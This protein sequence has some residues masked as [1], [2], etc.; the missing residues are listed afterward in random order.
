[1]SQVKFDVNPSEAKLITA[2]AERYAE[3]M[4]EHAKVTMTDEA[5]LSLRMDLTACHC[6]GCQL[7][8][9]DLLAAAEFDLAHD[10]GG[11]RNCMDRTTG[12]LNGGFLPR[13]ADVECPERG[14][15]FTKAERDGLLKVLQE[16]K[17]L[18]WYVVYLDD[19]DERKDYAAGTPLEDV[20]YDANQT[21]DVHLG[22]RFN[23]VGKPSANARI[24]LVWGN[25]PV[26]LI[27]DWSAALAEF[28]EA[29]EAAQKAV[30]PNYPEE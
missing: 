6:N 17:K 14:Q 4:K 29:I 27:A 3:V 2:I 1:M 23:Q 5:V 15:F 26:E 12:K 30:W 13:Y 8:L 20:V 11:I 16:L 24:Y 21:E 10:V 9:A 18:G 7:R 28:D 25:S 22:L 19:N